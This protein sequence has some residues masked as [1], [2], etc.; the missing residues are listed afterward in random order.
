MLILC[1]IIASS[2]LWAQQ[3][4]PSSVSGES[5]SVDYQ[6]LDSTTGYSVGPATIAWGV[7]GQ[8]SSIALSHSGVSSQNGRFVQQL[9]PGE[10]AFE[11]SAPGYK[12]MRTHSDVTPGSTDRANIDLDP[13]TPPLELREEA[14]K[15]ELRDGMELVHGYVANELTHRPIANATIKLSENGATATTNSRGYFQLYADAISTARISR[16][17]DY[18]P[19]DT[20]TVRAPGYETYILSGLL[21]VPGGYSVMRIAMTPGRGVTHEQELHTPLMPPGSLPEVAPPLANPTPKSVQNWLKVPGQAVVIGEVN[22]VCWNGHCCSVAA[23]TFRQ[24]SAA[25]RRL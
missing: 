15:S 10:Y 5:G 22:P 16:P 21:H 6:I 24:R 7:I 19:L 4:N 8:S 12:P 13:I 18:P 25:I 3:R 23:P 1:S 14:V 17:E 2:A 9:P 11:I 20:L